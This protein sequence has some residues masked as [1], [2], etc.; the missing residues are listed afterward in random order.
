MVP[1]F[2]MYIGQA[3]TN[4]TSMY[5]SGDADTALDINTAVHWSCYNIITYT[6]PMGLKDLDEN[7]LTI[8][9]FSSRFLTC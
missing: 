2:V 6:Q 8:S 7:M 3:M 1:F 4:M 9:M 5:K